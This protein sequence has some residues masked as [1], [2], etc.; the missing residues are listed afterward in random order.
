MLQ[1]Y[2]ESNFELVLL[3]N[4]R[5]FLNLKFYKSNEKK[6]LFFLNFRSIASFFFKFCN[7]INMDFFT[8]H[9]FCL[10]FWIIS[11][12]VGRV[13]KLKIDLRLGVYYY[14]FIL[15]H[16]IKKKLMFKVVSFFVDEFIKTQN[17][18]GHKLINKSLLVFW[19]NLDLLMNYKLARG[20]YFH[21]IRHKFYFK[22]SLLEKWSPFFL[23]Y[24]NSLKLYEG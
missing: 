2:V 7:I 1:K 14:N 20:V 6:T 23:L 21:H 11:G 17:W 24:L 9:R 4:S 16:L 12:S 3:D 10:V 15:K 22:V 19:D 13:H 8:V 18:S 5:T